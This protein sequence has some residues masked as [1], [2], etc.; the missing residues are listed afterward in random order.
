[1][2]PTSSGKQTTPGKSSNTQPPVTRTSRASSGRDID[3]IREEES[4]V[5]GAKDGALFLEKVKLTISGN[6]V[7]S[8]SLVSTLFHITQMQNIPLQVKNAIRSVAF[9]LEKVNDD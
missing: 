8:A 1:M 9:L 3:E 5:K 7:N 6:T 2:A 4:I